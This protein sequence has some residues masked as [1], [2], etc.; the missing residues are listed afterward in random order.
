MKKILILLCA[1]CAFNIQATVLDVE[2]TQDNWL[3]QL[4]I[5]GDSP[6]PGWVYIDGNVWGYGSTGGD[7]M[8]LILPEDYYSIWFLTAGEHL[9]TFQ[10]DIIDGLLIIGDEPYVI[11]P[12]IGD[13]PSEGV[14]DNSGSL[15]LA[16]I[17]LCSL[18]AMRHKF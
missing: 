12:P 3:F 6:N 9:V 18:T 10:E 15:A 17:G 7:L 11:T 16:I 4:N 2:S 5:S 14:P 1:L 8:N 13:R